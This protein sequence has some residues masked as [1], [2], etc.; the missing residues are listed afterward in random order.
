MLLIIISNILF[1][2]FFSIYYRYIRILFVNNYFALV[3]DEQ[4]IKTNLLTFYSPIAR[5]IQLGI[6]INNK[7]IVIEA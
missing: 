2:S 7:Y 6:W 3:Y 1:S 4:I 5:T